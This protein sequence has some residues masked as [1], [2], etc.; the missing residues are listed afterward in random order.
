VEVAY[1]AHI[2]GSTWCVMATNK[3]KPAK[4]FPFKSS[5][6][7][8]PILGGESLPSTAEVDKDGI[9]TITDSFSQKMK[10]FEE[11]LNSNLQFSD[12]DAYKKNLLKFLKS[13]SNLIPGFNEKNKGKKDGK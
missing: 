2:P 11:A 4:L 7:T 10:T 1:A 8:S 9:F 12:I 5:K 13:D 6:K 3:I